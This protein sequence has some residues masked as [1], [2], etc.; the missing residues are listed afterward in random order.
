MTF[1]QDIVCYAFVRLRHLQTLYCDGEIMRGSPEHF[2]ILALEELE[3][4]WVR[5][6]MRRHYAAE[7]RLPCRNRQRRGATHVC[8]HADGSEPMSDSRH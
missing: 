1:Q 5:E 7:C 4:L 3:S 6:E 8:T 2:E